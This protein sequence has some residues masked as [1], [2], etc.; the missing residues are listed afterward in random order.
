MALARAPGSAG[1]SLLALFIRLGALLLQP[2]LAL[3]SALE[4]RWAAA[5]DGVMLV[6]LGV[7]CCYTPEVTR[8]GLATWDLGL[9][10]GINELS[11]TLGRR[12]TPDF[13]LLL[14]IVVLVVLP[15][16]LLQ[17]LTFDRALDLAVACWIPAFL[18]RLAGAAWRLQ[19]GQGPARLFEGLDWWVGLTWS[20]LLV[21]YSLILALRDADA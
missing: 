2:N 11:W 1:K 10:E 20:G 13:L 15:L 4:G 9:R 3:R 19:T 16:R 8:V 14:G 21:A 17:R 5:R 6:L 18:L 7:I 12:L